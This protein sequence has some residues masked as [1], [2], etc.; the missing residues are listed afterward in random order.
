MDAVTAML[1]KDHGIGRSFTGEYN[2]YFGANI[3]EDALVY[4]MLVCPI[5]QA[6]ADAQ[7]PYFAGQACARRNQ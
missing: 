7:G 2:E 5:P 6:P 4:L 3:D 1:F